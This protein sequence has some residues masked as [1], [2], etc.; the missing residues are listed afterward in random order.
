MNS[1][2]PLNF[3]QNNQEIHINLHITSL[4]SFYTQNDHYLTIL[5]YKNVPVMFPLIY[6]NVMFECS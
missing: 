6:K 3:S 5:R 2:E 4:H 1:K